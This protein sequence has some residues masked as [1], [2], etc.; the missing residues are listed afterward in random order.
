MEGRVQE[1]ITAA[2]GVVEEIGRR[3]IPL[4]VLL[5]DRLSA[6]SAASLDEQNAIERQVLIVRNSLLE[7]QRARSRAA[8]ALNLL[9]NCEHVLAPRP[10]TTAELVAIARNTQLSLRGQGLRQGMQ[11]RAI[12]RIQNV[13]HS[14]DALDIAIWTH[15]DNVVNL[16][17]T[18]G[19]PPT[20]NSIYFAINSGLWMV[21]ALLNDPH[22]E[23]HRDKLLTDNAVKYALENHSSE[24][25]TMVLLLDKKG[26]PIS[27]EIR[28]LMESESHSHG[29]GRVLQIKEHQEKIKGGKWTWEEAF[30]FLCTRGCS[31]QSA[32][33]VDER[34][35]VAAGAA[36]AG[37]AAADLAAESDPAAASLPPA[38]DTDTAAA[39]VAP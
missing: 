28:E 11:Q 24:L 32:A 35:E 12:E 34:K 5:N 18:V 22:L 3:T 27:P 14:F 20:H 33:A 16:F 31:L 1:A 36:A 10:T 37:A 4:Q 26:E 2:V 19:V 13:N 25:T 38:A 9:K 7:D 39:P 17:F 29:M 8:E 6:A 30:R 23:E 15:K 21:T